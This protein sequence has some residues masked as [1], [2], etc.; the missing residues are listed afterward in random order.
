MTRRWLK[1]LPAFLLLCALVS[2]AALSVRAASRV[3]GAEFREYRRKEPGNGDTDET[4]EEKAQET[5][6]E[7]GRTAEGGYP[8]L[9]DWIVWQEREITNLFS[10]EDPAELAG[11]NEPCTVRLHDR[12]AV[13]TDKAGWI[14]YESP[15]DLS[16]QDVLVTD[17][18]FDGQRELVLLCWRRGHYDRMRPFW[19]REATREYRQHIYIYDWKDGGFRQRWL[20]SNIIIDVADWSADTKNVFTLT[21]PDGTVSRWA[22]GT[23]GLCLLDE[24]PTSDRLTFAAV[25]DDLMHMELVGEA[26]QRGGFDYMFDGT[27]DRLQAADLAILNQETPLVADMRRVAGYPAFGTPYTLGRA[28]KNAG[29]DIVSCATNH[30]LDQGWY[31]VCVS[32]A[33]FT[34]NDILC[35]GIQTEPEYVPYRSLTMHGIRIA[36]LNYTEITNGYPQPKENP[37]AVH[38]LDD[39]ARVREDLRLAREDADLVLVLVHWGTE[40]LTYPDASELRWS[41]VFLEEGAD[42]VIGTHPHVLQPYGIRVR[43]DGHEMLVYYSLGNFIS[44]QSQPARMLGGLAEFTVTKDE[45]GVHIESYGMEPV[46]T[47]YE[48]GAFGTYL[49][50]DYTDELAARHRIGITREGMQAMFLEYTSPGGLFQK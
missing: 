12:R 22:W 16:V 48:T 38:T 29:F 43:E 4:E 47:H 34:E 44:A 9:P 1:I 45:E 50:S 26:S 30:A 21:E 13:V 5:E 3:S 20:A 25:G 46:V 18:D 2:G 37:Y 36:V 24:I 35:A 10:W 17:A 6:N 15:E 49:L 23:W 27:R 7:T 33:F 41:D 42:V 11:E 40:Y 14:L 19:V 32:E 31:G 28:V 8:E 39:E